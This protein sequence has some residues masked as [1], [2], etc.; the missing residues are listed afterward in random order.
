LEAANTNLAISLYLHSR[1]KPNAKA[2]FCQGRSYNY[3]EFAQAAYQIKVC[4]NS[5]INSHQRVRIGILG[6]RSFHSYA[7]VMGTLWAGCTYVPLVAKQPIAHLNKL[8]EKA[9][10]EVLIVDSE[11]WQIFRELTIQS[12]TIILSFNSDEHNLHNHQA[13]GPILKI[14]TNKHIELQ[15][16]SKNA[17]HTPAYIIFTS[18]TTGEPK[19]CAPTY[20]QV[21]QFIDA[22]T[23]QYEFSPCDRFAQFCELAFDASV[24]ILFTALRLGAELF[25]LPEIQRL[26][27][28]KFLRQHEISVFYFMPSIVTLLKRSHQLKSGVLP[29]L[30]LTFFGAEALTF[31]TAQYWKSVA[32]NSQIENFYGPTESTVSCSAHTVFSSQEKIVQSFTTAGTDTLP[33]GLPL[34]GLKMAIIDNKHQFLKEHHFLKECCFLA[35]NQRGE[36]V[37]CGEQVLDNYWQDEKQSSESFIS[38]T[39]P[40]YGIQKW[41]LSGDLGFRDKQGVYHILGRCDSQIQLRGQRLELSYIQMLLRQY[42]GFE[43]VVVLP[44]PKKE[45]VVMGLVAV[46]EANKIDQS[47]IFQQLKK[48][49]P[50]SSMPD[51]LLHIDKLP[52]NS[53]GKV[54]IY[55][56]EL[57]FQEQLKNP[58]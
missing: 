35:D 38:L 33:I 37:I 55:A 39:H 49:L 36:I 6:G 17:S 46:I 9:D 15:A 3:G 51:T 54:D 20:K 25:V 41:Y 48:D 2:I 56:L 30:R 1:H 24:F 10:I 12:A 28:L 27:P 53:N 14:A 45:G 52:R 21:N 7:A 57:W 26:M 42:S 16:P 19:A 47:E 29:K 11:G 40:H 8:I 50:S 22:M 58:Y 43:D 34:P 18:G 31:K 5:A 44:W 23:E 13:N 32:P 4:I